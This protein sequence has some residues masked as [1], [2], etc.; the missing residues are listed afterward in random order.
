M[1]DSRLAAIQHTVQEMLSAVH[2][3]E[4]PVDEIPAAQSV[5]SQKA[6]NTPTVEV[7]SPSPNSSSPSSKEKELKRQQRM[8]LEQQML[9][10][11]VANN[12]ARPSGAAVKRQ[13]VDSRRSMQAQ[14]RPPQKARAIVSKQR[15][16]AEAAVPKNALARGIHA[17]VLSH[18]PVQHKRQHSAANAKKRAN[19]SFHGSS[20][21][22]PVSSVQPVM[23]PM[24]MLGP[25]PVMVC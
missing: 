2:N 1:G 6:G 18:Q 17:L 5:D 22:V 10:R 23:Q 9:Q 8:Q 21:V 19:P 24:R 25:M 12:A 3:M 15:R 11:M 4:D 20:R 16:Q 14:I 7:S 13:R